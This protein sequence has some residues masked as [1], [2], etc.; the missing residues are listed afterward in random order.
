MV[1]GHWLRGS[2]QNIGEGGAYLLTFQDEKFSPG[3]GIY[4]VCL[5]QGLAWAAQG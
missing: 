4:L 1:H 5:N 3:E 2:I